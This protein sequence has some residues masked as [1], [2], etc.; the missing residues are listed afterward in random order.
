MYV[1]PHDSEIVGRVQAGDTEA[2]GVL[3]DRYYAECYRYAL[4]MLLEA[5]EAEDAVQESFINAYRAL[6]RYRDQGRFRAWLF[7]IL[8]NRC[9]SAGRRRRGVPLSDA[10]DVAVEDPVDRKVLWQDEIGTALAA[11]SPPLREAFLLKHMEELSYDEMSRLTGDGVSAL[12]MRVA[13]ACH[14]LRATLQ[15]TLDDR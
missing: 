15:E 1:E 2:F 14:M 11:L 10:P 4:R 3:V 7:R 5:D 6:P 8:L 13:R 12:K 9:R